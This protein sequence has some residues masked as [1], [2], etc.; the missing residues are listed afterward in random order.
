[1]RWIEQDE[2]EKIRELHQKWRGDEA[3]RVDK[4][5]VVEDNDL[6]IVGIVAKASSTPSVGFIASLVVQPECRRRGIGASLVAHAI[7]AHLTGRP[8][9]ALVHRASNLSAG[10]L[11]DRL[12]L[13][14]SLFIALDSMQ[15][16]R[17]WKVVVSGFSLP[18]FK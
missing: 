12:G 2:G 9:G 15:L 8:C 5:A 7:N 6:N 3:G 18:H 1:M 16:A 13:N 4:W 14:S 17:L 10:Q 11:Y